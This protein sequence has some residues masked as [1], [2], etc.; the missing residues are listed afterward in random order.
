MS[1]YTEYLAKCAFDAA[2]TQLCK[3]DDIDDETKAALKE[4]M[5]HWWMQEDQDEEFA[6]G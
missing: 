5:Q 4:E 3:T 6:N 1:A 2:M